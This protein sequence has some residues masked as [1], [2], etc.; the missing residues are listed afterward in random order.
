MQIRTKISSSD[1]D[2]GEST[3]PIV[4]FAKAGDSNISNAS[5]VPSI[6]TLRSK[7]WDKRLGFM[8]G[9]SLGSAD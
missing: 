1:F 2:F 7:E 6:A 9:G 3:T 8:T 4:S 5:R